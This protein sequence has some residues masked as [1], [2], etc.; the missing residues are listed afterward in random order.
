MYNDVQYTSLAQEEW[1]G[2]P[3]PG[4]QDQG[5]GVSTSQLQNPNVSL[6]S[7]K[8]ATGATGFFQSPAMWVFLAVLLVVVK[9]VAEKAGKREEFA[10]VRIGL[11]NWFL[12]G[13]MAA[14]YFFAAK[15]VAYK[16]R[17]PVL[18]QF[19]GFI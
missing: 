7:T 12:V 10:T 16:T 14:L 6:A 13:T 15:L 17:I 3:H 5:V 19:F 4:D 8:N 1:L 9:F 11:E 18:M 2:E